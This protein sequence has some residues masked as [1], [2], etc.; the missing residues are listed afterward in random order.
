MALVPEP[1]NEFDEH[2]IAV[3]SSRGV[4]LGYLPSERAVWIGTILRRGI[5]VRAVFQAL[6]DSVAW[7]RIAFEGDEPS[8]PPVADRSEVDDDGFYPDDP[9]G[10]WGA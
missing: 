3:F 1:K 6:G 2:A 5:E 7:C 8:L 4:Q 9:A 10:D